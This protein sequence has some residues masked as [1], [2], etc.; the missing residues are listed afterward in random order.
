MSYNMPMGCSV[1]DIPGI[2]EPDQVPCPNCGGTG[3][4]PIAEDC[5]GE[6]CGDCAECVAEHGFQDVCEF[7]NGAKWVDPPEFGESE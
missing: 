5:H 2:D 4:Q 1:A 3:L 6:G 7:C